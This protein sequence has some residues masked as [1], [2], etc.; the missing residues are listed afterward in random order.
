[1][2]PQISINMT[3]PATVVIASKAGRLGNRLFLSAYF[4]A[5]ALAKG[6]R[7]LNPALG[8]YAALFEGSAHDPLC[9]FPVSGKEMD[10]E[11]ATQCREVLLSAAA[12]AGSFAGR[13]GVPAMRLIDIRV[14]HDS[15]D[16]AFDLSGQ[17][18]EECLQT[19]RYLFV[20]G[21][22][23]RDED[24]LLRFHSEISRYF[25]PVKA[26]RLSAEAA[27]A[28]ARA[29]GDHL[30]GVHI[31]QGDYRGWKNGAHYFET[32]QYAHWMRQVDTLFPRK[33]NIFLVCASDRIVNTDLDGLNMVC[34]PGSAVADLHALSLCDK[35]IGPPSTF[36][37]WASYHGR[38]PHCMLQNHKQ[39]VSLE[40]FVL[41]DRV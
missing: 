18:F 5:N 11:L 30:V 3:A 22:K 27:I 23:F 29:R 28:E 10:V 19:N 36:S 2:E 17:S 32:S 6:Y 9:S 12:G 33:K 24:N 34:G 15:E 39:N 4:M 31:R 41:H 35:M 13:I 26:V 14:S 1:L 40:G 37:T 20:K 25:T 16:R 38:V 21:W 7:L 8:E